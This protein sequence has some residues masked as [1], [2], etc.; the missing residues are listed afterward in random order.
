MLGLDLYI[1]QLQPQKFFTGD[2]AT[3]TPITSA[4]AHEFVFI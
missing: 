1:L 3:G 4:D 2:I